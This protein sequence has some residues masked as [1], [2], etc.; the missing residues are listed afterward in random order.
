[1]STHDGFFWFVLVIASVG[2]AS[3]GARNEC[4][5][6]ITE[7]AV[8]SP[9]LFAQGSGW[10]EGDLTRVAFSDVASLHLSFNSSSP[11]SPLA[12]TIEA[13]GI[14]TTWVMKLTPARPAATVLLNV[15]RWPGSMMHGLRSTAT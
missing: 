5:F 10:V 12:M 9:A 14:S 3:V 4:L 11:P 1:M 13:G 8:Q 2:A 15:S 6:N 7:H